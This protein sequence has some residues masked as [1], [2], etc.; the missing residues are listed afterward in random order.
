MSA[1]SLFFSNSASR[2]PGKVVN[3]LIH[4]LLSLNYEVL[5]NIY[6]PDALVGCLQLVPNFTVL[7]P[8]RT[9]FGPNLF[10]LP[11]EITKKTFDNNLKH[12]V[13]PSLW[14]KNV[15][16]TFPEVNSC[17]I[18]VWPVGIN[19]DEWDLSK[20]KKE[21]HGLLYVKNRG[22]RDILL[23][24]KLLAK[25]GVTFDVIEYGNYKEEELKKAC[26]SASFAVLL[27][28]T[29]SQGIAYMQILSSGIPCYVFNVDTWNNEGKSKNYSA[30]SVPY[31]DGRC[32]TIANTVSVS[33][34]QDFL[35]KLN[36]Y[37]PRDYILENHTLETSAA[38][39]IEIL[40]KYDK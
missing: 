26:E 18:D 20:N 38:A 22:E 4:G 39:Y 24:K 17:T 16:E 8:Q 19:T 15:Y 3:N 35:Q 13:V 30:S 21:K 31:F 28:G 9:V 7:P 11:D 10:V 14:V 5:E 23:V 1:V 40:K 34:F 2:G 36:N 29:E 32:G 25:A 37:Q 33:H 6:R 27:T 12:L